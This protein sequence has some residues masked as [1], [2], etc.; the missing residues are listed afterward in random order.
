MNIAKPEALVLIQVAE[1]EGGLEHLVFVLGV[2]MPEKVC[3]LRNKKT[4]FVKFL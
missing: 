3:V 2:I 4:Y 1:T